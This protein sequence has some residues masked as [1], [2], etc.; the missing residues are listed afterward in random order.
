MTKYQW[1]K[2][3]MMVFVLVAALS[4]GSSVVAVENKSINEILVEDGRFTTALAA[5]NVAG[6]AVDP[7][8]RDW[9]VF[10]PT[11]EAFAKLGLNANNIASGSSL[12]EIRDDVLYG[13]MQGKHDTADLL[14]MVG[15]ITMANGKVAGLKVFEDDF[16]LNDD[17]KIIEPDIFASNGVIHV[18]DTII[19][20]PWPRTE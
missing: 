7:L 6:L 2:T 11:D 5:V 9:T 18:V 4:Y 19:S 10:V 17:S 20:Q 16:Y 12:E 14:G 3:I 1:M 15:N 13:M 8:G